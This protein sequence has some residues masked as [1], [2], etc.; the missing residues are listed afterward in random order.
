MKRGLNRKGVSPV[1]AT[2]LLIAIVIV[3]ALI[4]FLWF[5]GL[6][7]DTIIKFDKNIEL[8]CSEVQF[9]AQYDGSILFV[10]NDGNIP[11]YGLNVQIDSGDGD[12]ET[13]EINHDG[14]E[15][16]GLDDNGLTQGF[17]YSSSRSEFDGAKS[18]ILIPVLK[19]STET[20]TETHICEKRDGVEIVI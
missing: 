6:A 9:N 4:I 1:I 10:S 18:I 17:T 3:I 20:G 12:Y 7:Q 14:D 19:G 8:V 13:L 15:N 2:V 5:R 11:I 16:W